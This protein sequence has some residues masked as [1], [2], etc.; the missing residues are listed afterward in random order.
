MAIEVAH[1]VNLNASPE[2]VWEVVG[3]FGSI[4]EWHPA[5]AK[6]EVFEIEG[7]TRRRLTTADGVELL[8]KLLTHDDAAMSYTYSIEESPLPVLGYVAEIRVATDADGTWIG[9]L[10]RF[11]PKGVSDADGRSVIMAIY[12]PGL[13]NV[14]MLVS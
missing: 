2:K 13:A 9:W 12:E 14:K 11:L 8:E 3:A 10:S 1:W 4:H 7:T 6:C 5:I